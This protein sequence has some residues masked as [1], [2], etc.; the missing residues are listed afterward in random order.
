M[1]TEDSVVVKQHLLLID[2]GDLT[3]EEVLPISNLKEMVELALSKRD[4]MDD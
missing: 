2:R 1:F 4:S 3:L